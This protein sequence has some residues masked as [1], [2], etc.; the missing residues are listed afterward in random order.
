MFVRASVLKC[1]KKSSESKWQMMIAHTMLKSFQLV[2]KHMATENVNNK[3]KKGDS[4]VKLLSN[5]NVVHGEW[6]LLWCFVLLNHLSPHVAQ[7]QLMSWTLWVYMKWLSILFSF[8]MVQILGMSFAVF[9]EKTLVWYADTVNCEHRS[10]EMSLWSSNSKDGTKSTER[11]NGTTEITMAWFCVVLIE[12]TNTPSYTQRFGIRRKTNNIQKILI[13]EHS[14]FFSF[15][16]RLKG[17]FKRIHLILP[18]CLNGSGFVSCLLF[19]FRWVWYTCIGRIH[20]NS[21]IND[22]CDDSTQ[23]N[24]S[25]HISWNEYASGFPCKL[26]TSFIK[27]FCILRWNSIPF[28]AEFLCPV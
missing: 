7:K 5:E 3:R 22:S 12:T 26:T 2:K 20:T 27:R 13:N 25:F 28:D 24:A 10:K 16:S 18:F 8:R 1:K 15:T 9:R 21:P 6:I 19:L 14:F 23:F 11:E 4:T 17:F